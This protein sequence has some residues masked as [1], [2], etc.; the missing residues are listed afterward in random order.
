MYDIALVL[1]VVYLAVVGAIL[2]TKII[3]SRRLTI[4]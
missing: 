3:A 4:I 1:A 2:V